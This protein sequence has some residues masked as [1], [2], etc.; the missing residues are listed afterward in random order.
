MTWRFIPLETRDAFTN[1]A[2]DEACSEGVANGRVPPTIRFYQWLPSAVSIGY[3]QRLR[4]EVNLDACRAAGVAVVRRRTGGGAVYHD[5]SGEIT[6]SVIGSEKLFPADIIAS[7]RQICGWIADGLAR[8][9]LYAEFK[10]INDL[11][12][13]GKKISGNAQT[14]RGG[15]LLQHGTILYEVDVRKMFSL[16]NVSDEKIRDKMIASAQERVTSIRAQS[17]ASKQQVY[18]ALLAGFTSH[19]EFETG[20]W[21]VE[22]LQRAEQL[23]VKRY[24]SP[25]WNNQR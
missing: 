20:T 2:L 7:Y 11:V 21:T 15:V 24:R 8:V 13:G 18:E 3:F 6:Y 10:P 5:S 4:D 25:E 17:A 12:L 9:N 23:A 1:M 14:R 19:K 22:E 16:L